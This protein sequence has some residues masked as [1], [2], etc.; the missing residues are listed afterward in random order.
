M[1][2]PFMLLLSVLLTSFFAHATVSL[3][4]IFSSNMVLQRD[5]P[6]PVFGFATAG[7]S[8][9]VTLNGVPVTGIADNNGKWI[10]KIPSM[11]FGGPY[12]LNLQG[13]SNSLSF[14][15]VMVGDVYL[16]CGQSN[17]EFRLNQEASSTTEIPASTNSNIRLMLVPKNLNTVAQTDIP[18]ATWLSCDP[19]SSATFSAVGYYFAKNLQSNLNIPVGMISSAWYGTSIRSWMGWD[20]V[21]KIDPTYRACGDSTIEMVSK[22]TQATFLNDLA[23]STTSTVPTFPSL[24]F[25]GMINPL[26]QFAIKGVLW[27]QG[28][29][30]VS[31]SLRYKPL[32]QDLILDWR[33]KWGYDFS[34]IW[35]QLP[36][37]NAT[38]STPQESQWAEQ[39]DVQNSTLSVPNTAQVVIYDL[40]DALNLHPTN[41]KDVGFRMCQNALRLNYGQTNLSAGPVLTKMTVSGSSLVLEFSNAGTGL[42]AKNNGGVL[43]GFTIAGLDRKFYNATATIS[44]NKLTVSSP[45]VSNPAIVRYGWY[46]NPIQ[47]NLVNSDGYLASPFKSFI[48]NAGFDQFA[49]NVTVPLQ[50]QICY[51]AGNFNAWSQTA[52]QLNYVS[53]DSVAGTKQFTAN[54]PY[55]FVT[56][57]SFQLMCGSSWTFAAAN[58]NISAVTA[59]MSQAVTVLSFPA[60]P[61]PLT[62]NVTV[63]I[64]VNDCYVAG[65]P[66]SWVLPAGAQKMTLTSSTGSNKVFSFTIYDKVA[67]HNIGVKFLAGLDAAKW[68][69]SQTAS[70]NFA[71]L[72]PDATCNFNCDAFAAYAPILTLNH[73][74]SSDMYSVKTIDKHIEVEGKFSNV[75]LFNFQGSLIQSSRLA[76]TFKSTSLAPG[77]YVLRVDNKAYKQLIY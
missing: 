21:K 73:D 31:E 50:T 35:V 77:V 29:A 54:L 65:S 23:T 45:S 11:A 34:F 75:T 10:V 30:N 39:R 24:L 5:M 14:T 2:K 57:G 51:V 32:F 27:Y 33:K 28:E 66:W 6:I 74:L 25:N 67:S 59:G 1:K 17:M 26:T 49:L 46:E 8:V 44:G 72:G 3:P 60:Y 7:E 42:S 19:T 55:S 15:N 13:A 4:K 61:F 22:K 12:S 56:S 41:K 48:P 40:G 52:N 69:Y 64:A 53:T 71:Y 16:C 37:F 70:A 36:G 58:G 47:A 20:E 9:T 62:I 38:T 68:T 76:N 18:Q 43:N 63:P